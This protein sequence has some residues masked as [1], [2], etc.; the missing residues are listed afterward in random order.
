M[1][2]SWWALHTDESV[3]DLRDVL[4]AGLGPGGELHERLRAHDTDFDPEFLRA[5][6]PGEILEREYS[7]GIG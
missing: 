3:Q 4:G 5:A 2:L 7:V 1:P 6:G